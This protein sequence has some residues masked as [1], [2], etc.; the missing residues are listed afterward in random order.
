MSLAKQGWLTRPYLVKDLDAKLKAIEHTG[1][2][3][4]SIEQKVVLTF[5]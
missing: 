5:D 3:S 4:G 1:Q 2:E